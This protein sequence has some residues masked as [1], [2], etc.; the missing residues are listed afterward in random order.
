MTLYDRLH[1][2]LEDFQQRW[3]DALDVFPI[4]DDV[5]DLPVPYILTERAA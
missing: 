3:E 5:V 4:E 2:M 1:A